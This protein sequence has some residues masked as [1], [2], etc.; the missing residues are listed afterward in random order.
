MTVSVDPSVEAVL[1]Y[2]DNRCLPPRK[3]SRGPELRLVEPRVKI[4]EWGLVLQ[5]VVRLGVE[6]NY[7]FTHWLRFVALW[8]L[9]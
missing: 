7:L 4:L 3:S 5:G 9:P 6:D 2:V 1:V 8:A